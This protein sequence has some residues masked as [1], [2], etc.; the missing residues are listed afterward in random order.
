[1]TSA[2]N[3]RVSLVL[4]ISCLAEEIPRGLCCRDFFIYL[5]MISEMQEFAYLCNPG[6]QTQNEKTQEQM[7]RSYFK[8]CTSDLYRSS[9]FFRGMNS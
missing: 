7:A 9:H 8:I 6:G 3:F 4:V 2:V 5:L 1:M